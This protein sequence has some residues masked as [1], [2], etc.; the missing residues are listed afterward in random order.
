MDMDNA[1]TAQLADTATTGAGI[2]A[3][4]Q[5][6]NPVMAPLANGGPIGLVAMAGIKLGFNQLGRHQEPETCRE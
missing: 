2:A 5:E 4:F 3:G 1:D 6:V